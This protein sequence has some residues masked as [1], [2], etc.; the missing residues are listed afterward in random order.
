MYA[1]YSDSATHFERRLPAA[2]MT[3]SHYGKMVRSGAQSQSTLVDIQHA[4]D[5]VYVS[6]FEHF[7]INGVILKT[8]G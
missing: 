7:S 4:L 8:F 2:T 5:R 1:K 3:R 6:L